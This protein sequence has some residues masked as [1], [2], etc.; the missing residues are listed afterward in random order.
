MTDQRRDHPAIE[1]LADHAAGKLDPDDQTTV[2]RHLQQCVTCRLE[3]QQLAR[4]ES[5]DEDNE[6]L[7]DSQWNRARFM[8][9]AGYRTRVR[10]VVTESLRR[11]GSPRARVLR[12]LAPVA[13]AAVL[14][15]ALLSSNLDRQ[16]VPRHDTVDTLRGG[17]DPV[18]VV[19]S[20]EGPQGDLA[21][22]PA[23]FEWRSRLDFESYTLEIF[24]AALEPVYR[25]G[26][27]QEK[28]MAVEDSL[29]LLLK[30]G[31]TYLWSVKGHT[32]LSEPQISETI[33]FK[34][35]P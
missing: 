13:V 30:P 21:Q 34:I 16:I 20:P 14:T 7:D 3:M 23:R 32:G 2:D 12:W 22:A 31:E 35:A 25:Q 5:I 1:Q 11:E 9:E 26:G 8:L 18:E 10:P 17:G 24:S 33:W 4:F 28:A 19:I 6:L 15:V 29:R 27:L